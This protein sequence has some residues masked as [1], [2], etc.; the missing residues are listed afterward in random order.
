[1]A[2]RRFQLKYNTVT[3][4]DI[5]KRLEAQESIQGYIRRLI[6]SDIMADSLQG[7][8]K[9]ISEDRKKI[10]LHY[11]PII[12]CVTDVEFSVQKEKGNKNG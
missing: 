5:I 12:D 11:C 3:D 9:V 10:D 6:W 1:M 2:S 7:V 4:A 8:F